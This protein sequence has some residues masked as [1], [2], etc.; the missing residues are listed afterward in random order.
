MRRI[1]I[2]GCVVL[3]L[4]LNPAALLAQTFGVELHNTLMPAAGGMGGASIAQP[5]DLTSAINA[6]P[7]TL[8][9]FQ[10]TQFLFGGGWA[11]PTF[12]LTQDSNI[13]I[14]GTPLIEPFSAK[15]T[16]PGTPAGNIGVTQDLSELGMPATLGLGFVTTSGG[17]VDFRHIP[18][19]NGTNSGSAI[20]NLPVALGLDLTD[21]LS[22]GAS[23]ALGIAFFDGP[24]VG[25]SGMTPDYALRG[26]LGANYRITEAT[27]VGGYY[28]TEQSFRFDNAVLINPGPTQTNFD[29][30][31][32]LPQNLGLGIANTSLVDGCLLLAVDVLYKQWDQAALYQAVYDNQWVIQL[33]AQYSLRNYRL[34]AGYAW[35]ENPIDDTPGS[36][37]GGVVQPGGFPA[38]RYTQGLLAITSQHRISAGIGVVDILPGLDMDLMAGGMFRDEEQ[39]GDF[40]TTSIESYWIGLGITWRF[41]RGSCC[42]LPAPDSWC[43]S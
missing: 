37:L 8:T 5:Q 29:V 11:E 31:M 27:T 42:T 26:T 15:S 33:G 12:N 4:A 21:R 9:Q 6:N 3:T 24:F 13:P 18:E 43:G 34:R 32:D 39:L 41:G 36:N 10:G 30:R 25:A 7:A 35:A 17:F 2:L 28:Q 40:T 16:S 1:L 20:F 14:V 23:L 38:V 19:S 22:V